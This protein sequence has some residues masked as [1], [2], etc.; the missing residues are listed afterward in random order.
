MKENHK[1]RYAEKCLYEYKKNLARLNVLSEDLR[2]LK[3]SSDVKAQSYNLI[4]SS[5]GRPSDPVFNYVVKIESIEEEIGKIRRVTDPIS[6]MIKDFSAPEVLENS[7]QH[8]LFEIMR[9][10]YF[11]NNSWRDVAQ[12][13]HIGKSLFFHCKKELVKCAIDYLGL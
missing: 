10:V 1:F 9:Y 13:L 2:V 4:F 12:E 11:G 7:Y 8:R 5:N 6:R 3:C